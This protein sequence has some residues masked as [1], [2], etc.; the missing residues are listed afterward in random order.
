MDIGIGIF[1]R[2]R[3]KSYLWWTWSWASVDVGLQHRI[4]NGHYNY[5]LSAVSSA[6]VGLATILNWCV[7]IPEMQGWWCLHPFLIEGMRRLVNTV[8]I[9][10][11]DM[12]MMEW[13][14]VVCGRRG[15][16][17]TSCVASEVCMCKSWTTAWMTRITRISKS[18]SQERKANYGNRVWNALLVLEDNV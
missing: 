8:E 7:V 1:P 3:I 16:G 9:A 11:L 15:E 18:G 5:T 17:R 4:T 2:M 14:W 12:E 13:E 10:S 6:S